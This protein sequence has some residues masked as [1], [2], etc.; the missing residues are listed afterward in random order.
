MP[1]S[2]QLIHK[3][4]NRQLQRPTSR[5]TSRYL[6]VTL[7]LVCHRDHTLQEQLP[8][9]VDEN[10]DLSTAYRQVMSLMTL[11]TLALILMTT[12]TPIT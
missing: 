1:R 6:A 8:Q 2:L 12:R 9:P 4:L 10:T 11:G 3:T 7:R 5:P